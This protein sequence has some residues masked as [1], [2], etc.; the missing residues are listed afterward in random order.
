[1]WDTLSITLEHG[2]ST[3]REDSNLSTS[4]SM[5]GQVC[6]TTFKLHRVTALLSANRRPHNEQIEEG[7]QSVRALTPE[8]AFLSLYSGSC[9][10]V[11]ALSYLKVIPCQMASAIQTKPFRPTTARSAVSRRVT[12]CK[13]T[14]QLLDA[15]TLPLPMAGCRWP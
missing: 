14:A 15:C 6:V 13:G 1:M 10:S 5:P 7:M 3:S 8:L 9:F 4:S 11:S 12:V 2:H